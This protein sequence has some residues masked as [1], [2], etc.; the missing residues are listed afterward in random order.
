MAIAI[1]ALTDAWAHRA[2]TICVRDLRELPP[3]AR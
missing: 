3:V 1:V 2:L